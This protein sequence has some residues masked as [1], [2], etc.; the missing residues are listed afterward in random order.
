MVCYDESLKLKVGMKVGLKN[1]SDC[2]LRMPTS[3]SSLKF[4]NKDIDQLMFTKK[5]FLVGVI[6]IF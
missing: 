5:Y 2:V 4:Q 6:C 3:F 1:C